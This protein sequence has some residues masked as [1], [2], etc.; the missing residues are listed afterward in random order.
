MVST[1]WFEVKEKIN[2]ARFWDVVLVLFLLSVFVTVPLFIKIID[3]GPL[4][5]NE[6]TLGGGDD[7]ELYETADLDDLDLY[8]SIK[9]TWNNVRTGCCYRYVAT[10]Y[11][12]GSLSVSY[13]TANSTFYSLLDVSADYSYR[14][15]Y[16]FT[17]SYDPDYFIDNDMYRIVFTL[18]RTDGP[19]HG[20]K[21]DNVKVGWH[22]NTT[23]ESKPQ[24]M[25]YEDR[26]RY[27][28]TERQYVDHEVDISL[29]DLVLADIMGLDFFYI[30]AECDENGNGIESIHCKLQLYQRT[31]ASIL[32]RSGLV[33]NQY[34]ELGFWRC[35][36]GCFIIA[37]GLHSLKIVDWL[38]VLRFLG[39]LC[40]GLGH[41]LKWAGSK[42]SEGG[43]AV[44]HKYKGGG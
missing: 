44:Y 27:N 43:S 15:G 7:Y 21:V 39:W 42:L 2:F 1:G 31:T 18:T 12:L 36:Y 19:F 29:S 32:V 20:D 23:A 14:L 25:I 38:K 28:D 11:E 16:Q 34:E 26:T 35:L 24:L 30:N 17:F 5:W 13:I 40:R 22:A 6:N 10:G 33:R 37:C 41:A 3:K 9:D 4:L 8:C